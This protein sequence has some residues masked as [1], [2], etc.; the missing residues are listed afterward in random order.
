MESFISELD[1]QVSELLQK[2][3]E[4]FLAIEQ[5]L[6]IMEDLKDQLE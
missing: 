4:L 2:K 6:A 5:G 3:E 1:N